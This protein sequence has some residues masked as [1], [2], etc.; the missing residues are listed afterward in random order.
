[1]IDDHPTCRRC[2]EPL[3]VSPGLWL[4]GSEKGKCFWQVR[5]VNDQCVGRVGGE[6]ARLY[7]YDKRNAMVRQHWD[8]GQD[9]DCETCSA[10]AA[11]GELRDVLR[12]QPD[13][14]AA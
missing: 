2:G 8:N 9:C 14:R 4:T 6:E 10:L 12:A 1:M 3:R 13:E 11:S 7:Y 5:C